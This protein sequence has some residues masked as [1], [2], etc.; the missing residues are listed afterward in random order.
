MIQKEG[1]P[2]SRDLPTRNPI[3][4][5][6]SEITPVKTLYA[7]LVIIALVQFSPDTKGQSASSKLDQVSLMRQFIGR[8]KGELA[9]DTVETMDIQTFGK[10]YVVSYQYLA[11]G[12]PYHEGRQLWG[13]DTNCENFMCYSLS[14][15][16]QFKMYTGKFTSRSKI[17]WEGK[18]PANPEKILSRYDWEFKSS[19]VV[20]IAATSEQGITRIFVYSKIHE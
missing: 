16:G 2:P 8:W 17:F 11:K 12:T 7:A 10:G 19:D 6:T 1:K 20:T 18:S 15:E 5:I 9:K 4:L 14:P 13:F 3:P